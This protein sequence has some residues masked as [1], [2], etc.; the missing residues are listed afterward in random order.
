MM[1]WVDWWLLPL[2]ITIGA[3]IWCNIVARDP[4][5]MYGGG[6]LFNL[7]VWM[8]GLIL[9]LIAWLCWAVLT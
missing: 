1:G 3:F 5:G 6:L 9:T 8:A 4:P 2:A 7:M